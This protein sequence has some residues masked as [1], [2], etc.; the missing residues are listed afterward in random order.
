MFARICILVAVFLVPIC[1]AVASDLIKIRSTPSQDI[2]VDR[3]TIQS[4]NGRASAWS[5]WNLNSPKNNSFNEPYQSV[6]IKNEYDCIMRTVRVVEV[7]EYA[8]PMATGT[9]LRAYSDYQHDEDR[10][11]QGSVGER[12]FELACPVISAGKI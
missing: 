5:L 10:I 1:N 9:P 11:P 3:E 6:V 4:G 12:I 2:F 7:L 8:A